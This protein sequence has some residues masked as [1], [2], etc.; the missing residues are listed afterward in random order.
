MSIR[1]SGKPLMGLTDDD[2]AGESG[3]VK[4]EPVD[5]RGK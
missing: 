1:D 4:D 2:E 3:M 5:E